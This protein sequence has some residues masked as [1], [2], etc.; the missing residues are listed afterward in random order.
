M[1]EF[2]EYI[3]QFDI[4][5]NTNFKKVFPEMAGL[6]DETLDNS[7]KPKI[8]EKVDQKIEKELAD[9]GTI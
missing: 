5:R 9:G 8:G 1:P 6:L 4:Q 2:R 3:T 7:I